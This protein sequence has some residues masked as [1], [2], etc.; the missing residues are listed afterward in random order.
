MLLRM[1]G[2][3]QDELMRQETEESAFSLEIAE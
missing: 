1:A 3:G 2:K